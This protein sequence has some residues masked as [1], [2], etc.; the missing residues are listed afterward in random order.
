MPEIPGHIEFDKNGICCI[1]GRQLQSGN[2]DRGDSGG[3]SPH[4]QKEQEDIFRRKINRFRSGKPYGCAVSVSGGKDS[5]AALYI[6]SKMGLHPLAIFI[7][8]GF[9]L[10]EMYENIKNAADILETD[11]IVYKTA[12]MKKLFR[13]LLESGK[14]IYYCRVCH[15][16]LD[17]QVR[18]ICAQNNI[19]LILGGYTKGQEY[20]RQKELAWIFEENDKNTAEVLSQN[21]GYGEIIKAIANPAFYCAKR[22]GNI[23][24]ISP[25]KYLPYDESRILKT[26]TEKLKFRLPENSW[27]RG[28]TNCLFN[29]LSQYLAMK[30][31]GY[32][33]HE[34]ELSDMIRCGEM[35]REQAE[36]VINTPIPSEYIEKV[37]GTIGIE[38]PET[39]L[40]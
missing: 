14:N 33:Q 1:C 35:N 28:S 13:T 15:I 7:D 19:R 17:I 32:S 8:N 11:V 37:L 4:T 30:Q 9:A 27:P 25:F 10:P 39:F 31:F 22:F 29:Y 2:S 6:A 16:L 21:G 40:R 24:E 20:I 3:I 26:I 38:N 18:K 34:T 36:R 5:I 12:E 23:A